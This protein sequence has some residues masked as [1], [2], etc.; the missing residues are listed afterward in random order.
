MQRDIQN[1]LR[2]LVLAIAILIMKTASGSEK[3]TNQSSRPN[4]EGGVVTANASSLVPKAV[5]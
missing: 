4:T 3:A 5:Y 1:L 2:L